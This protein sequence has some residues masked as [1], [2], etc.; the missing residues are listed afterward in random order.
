MWALNNL[1]IQLL[2]GKVS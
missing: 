2:V 1:S